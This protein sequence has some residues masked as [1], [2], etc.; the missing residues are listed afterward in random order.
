MRTIVCLTLV[1]YMVRMKCEQFGGSVEF[2]I[3]RIEKL[4]LS[5]TVSLQQVQQCPSDINYVIRFLRHVIDSLEKQQLEVHDDFYT[6]LCDSQS[7]SDD[8]SEY[9]H[10]HY[11]IMDEEKEDFA[12]VILKENRNKISQLAKMCG[13]FK[14]SIFFEVKMCQNSKL[15][16]GFAVS[17]LPN[18]VLFT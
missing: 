18:V 6:I 3:K 1:A 13:P 7:K 9:S 8:G 14:I 4:L 16:L 11:Q 12:T 10:K 17:L 15:A 5:E 2:K